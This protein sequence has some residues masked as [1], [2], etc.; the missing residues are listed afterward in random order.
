MDRALTTS[1]RMTETEIHNSTMTS[2]VEISDRITCD[3]IRSILTSV[4]QNNYPLKDRDGLD[5]RMLIEVIENGVVHTI[6]LGRF[7]MIAVDSTRVFSFS[8]TRIIN[9]LKPYIL[10][11]LRWYP[12]SQE[13]ISAYKKKRAGLLLKSLGN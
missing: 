2:N 5:V 3:S 9:L 7:E 8:S 13:E 10:P 1:V 12:A 11:D 6:S 4:A